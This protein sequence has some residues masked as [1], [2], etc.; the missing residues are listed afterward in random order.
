[1]SLAFPLLDISIVR[2]YLR[3]LGWVLFPRNG[4]DPGPLPIVELLV[5]G[6]PWVV[7]L[8]QRVL[9]DPQ[10]RSFNRAVQFG[11]LFYL[12]PVPIESGIVTFLAEAIASLVLRSPAHDTY[13]LANRALPL[14]SAFLL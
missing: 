2:M 11:S 4:V 3:L 1:M 7:L 13:S 5:E 10:S 9:V 12:P 8:F 14:C 6:Y